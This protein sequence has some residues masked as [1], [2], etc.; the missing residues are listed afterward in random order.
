MKV[1]VIVATHKKYRIPKDD[2]YLPLQV[3]AK[4]KDGLG[5]AKDDTGENISLKNP[6]FCELTGLYWA[7]KNRD[8]DYLGLVHYR[9]FFAGKRRCKDKFARILS[10]KEALKYLNQYDILVPKKRRYWIETL[11]SHYK[12]THHIETL[13]KTIKI[14]EDVYPEYVPSL[15]KV[16]KQTHMHAFNM[17]I[18]KREYLDLYCTWLFDILFRL[19]KEMMGIEYDAYQGRFY[20]R[21]SEILLDV[22]LD[23]NKYEYKEIPYIFM[24]KVNWWKKGTSF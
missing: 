1:K 15:K 16:L 3:G 17:F 8:D 14:I 12:H 5:Y 19:E 9:R 10:K 2:L 7:W 24:E 22:W 11:Y 21:V 6:F 20:G 4:N 13:D 18:M 23:Y